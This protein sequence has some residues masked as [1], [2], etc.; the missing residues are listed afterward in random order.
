MG[1]RS[2]RGS[3][4]LQVGPG[5]HL[6]GSAGDALQYRGAWRP[7]EAHRIQWDTA[8]SEVPCVGTGLAE[9]AGILGLWDALGVASSIV[10]LCLSLCPPYSIPSALSQLLCLKSLA[11]F[12]FLFLPHLSFSVLN[13]L[14][15]SPYSFCPISLSTV[16]SVDSHLWASQPSGSLLS[17]LGF[18][19]L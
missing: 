7:Q 12:P 5:C 14:Q 1:G 18:S 2:R 9:P 19:F 10:C 17:P 4:Q 16:V 15:P 6:S 13:P 8:G 3:C 11:A